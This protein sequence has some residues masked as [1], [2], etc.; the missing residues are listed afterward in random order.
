M[1]TLTMT[2]RYEKIK[3]A[4]IP[5]AQIL[6]TIRKGIHKQ[7]GI[8][9]EVKQTIITKGDPD[10]LG[11]INPDTTLVILSEMDITDEQSNKLKREAI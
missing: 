11:T 2:H 8:E 1:P 3:I 6:S 9:N 4:Q 7:F 5:E 10:G